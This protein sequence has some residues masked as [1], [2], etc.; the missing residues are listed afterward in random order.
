MKWGKI[1]AIE[2]PFKFTEE[3][4]DNKFK[5]IY[6]QLISNKKHSKNPSAVLVS[7]QPGAEITTLEEIILVKNPNMIIINVDDYRTYHPR[8]NQLHELYG[9]NWVLYTHN[10]SDQIY[11]KLLAGLSDEKYNLLIEGTLRTSE[12][13]LNFANKLK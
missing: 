13:P 5:I 1:M 10:F 3:E 7:G 6:A 9:D 4:L 8:F 2:E 11:K 12:I